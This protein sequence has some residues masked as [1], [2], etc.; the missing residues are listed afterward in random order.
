M[1]EVE[2][3]G[4]RPAEW[5]ERRFMDG[6][7]DSICK[8]RC[9]EKVRWRRIIGCGVWI[10][11]PIKWNCIF[12][13]QCNWHDLMVLMVVEKHWV[14]WPDRVRVQFDAHDWLGLHSI[15]LSTSSAGSNSTTP[16]TRRLDLLWVNQELSHT[17]PLQSP[18][19]VRDERITKKNLTHKW[20]WIAPE[21]STLAQA[22]P[23]LEDF[24]SSL[25]NCKNSDL[26]VQ[27]RPD[28]LLADSNWLS[29][30]PTLAH[31]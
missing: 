31:S 8:V 7:S 1:L 9:K 11:G 10:F 26:E 12:L 22:A 16:K 29:A 6:W 27:T 2:L 20:L 14:T 25:C 17:R 13:F 28:R 3:A 24:A 21:E 30:E 18:L 5:A 15:L 19:T 4:R 23:P